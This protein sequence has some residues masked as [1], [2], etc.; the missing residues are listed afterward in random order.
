MN[1]PIISPWLIYAVDVLVG[2]KSMIYNLLFALGMASFGLGIACMISVADG[3][4]EITQKL[5]RWIK[6]V[7][8]AVVVGCVLNMFIPDRTTIYQMI[9]AQFIT[10]ANL[11][12]GEEKAFQI[13]KRCVET[14][15]KK[16]E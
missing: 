12:Q 7:I 5:M 13:I 10:P 11:Q 6:C 2:V 9:A 1:E 15:N 16:G 14:V 4:K 8:M 3:D